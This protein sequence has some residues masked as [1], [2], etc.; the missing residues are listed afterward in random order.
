MER[1]TRIK[2]P[3]EMSLDKDWVEHGGRLHHLATVFLL[4]QFSDRK[5]LRGAMSCS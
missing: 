3:T 2:G 1:L 4:R 5:Q